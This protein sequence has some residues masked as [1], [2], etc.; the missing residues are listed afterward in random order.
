MELSELQ[1]MGMLGNIAIIVITITGS[2]GFLKLLKAFFAYFSEM[3]DAGQA[4]LLQRIET[5]EATAAEKVKINSEL[6]GEI[7]R[8][9]IQIAEANNMIKT[10]TAAIKAEMS[11]EQITKFLSEVS[12]NNE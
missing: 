1:N 6:M 3:K 9:R 12:E 10:L 5:L 7:S 2:G 8:L 4:E 11:Q